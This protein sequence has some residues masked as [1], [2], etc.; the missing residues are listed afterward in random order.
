MCRMIAAVGEHDLEALKEALLLMALNRNPAYEHEHRHRGD[1]IQHDCG[2]G[3]AF[4]TPDGLV[5][6]RSTRPCFDDPE[7]D[8]L[9]CDGAALAVLHAR[10]NR[11][12]STIAIDNT[13]PFT[14][15][16]RGVDY[17][18]FHN[19]DVRDRGQLRYD[20]SLTPS[21]SSDSE[22]LFFHVLT[23]LDAVRP[24]QSLR[25]ALACIT[26][27]TALN[28]FLVSPGGLT[29]Y[30]RMS[31]DSACPR[32][33]SLWR[34]SGGAEVL[35]SEVVSGVDGDWTSVPDGAA[36]RVDTP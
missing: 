19:G 2:W 29:V 30:A 15:T 3:A 25:T 6:R 36:L 13:H 23:T 14:A 32:Y 8:A 18:F 9:A 26:D 10:R 31:E 22:E 27:F 34:S 24:A 1:A 5:V 11:D 21:G 20:A 17:A 16:W 35:S 12:R 4:V 7:F 33:Y 28:C